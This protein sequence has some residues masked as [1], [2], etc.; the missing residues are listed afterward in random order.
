MSRV[1]LQYR[2]RFIV[3]GLGSWVFMHASALIFLHAI[4]GNHQRFQS[5]TPVEAYALFDH[6]EVEPSTSKISDR[7]ELVE[8]SPTSK[9]GVGGEN[10]MK[11]SSRQSTVSQRNASS[12]KIVV[13][14]HRQTVRVIPSHLP[15][16]T[17][18]QTSTPAD[19]QILE[20]AHQ[21]ATLLPFRI[22][23]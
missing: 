5:G 12:K 16:V 18:R 8:T 10:D 13:R 6:Y 17:V 14:A 15:H 19:G 11:Q 2:L 21:L 22:G 1:L 23:E 3:L 9:T 7:I 20:V 4:R